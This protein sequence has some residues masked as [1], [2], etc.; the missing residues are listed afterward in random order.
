MPSHRYRVIRDCTFGIRY[1]REDQEVTLE[2]DPEDRESIPPYH[3]HPLDGGPVRKAGP[4]DPFNN[5]EDMQRSDL[6][7]ELRPPEPNTYLGQRQASNDAGPVG[8][9]RFRRPRTSP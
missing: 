1:Y 2:V 9:P 5:Q 3:F 8:G 6:L 7:K 4:K